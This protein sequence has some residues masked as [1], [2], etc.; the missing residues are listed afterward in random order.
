MVVEARFEGR[1]RP[2]TELVIS[3]LPDPVIRESRGRLICALKENGLRVPSG[4]LYLN[5]VPAA[6]RK[7]GGMLDLPIALGAAAAC[8]HIDPRWLQDTLFVGELGIDG[9]LHPVPGGLAAASCARESGI[10]QLV[11]SLATAREAAWIGEVA[12]LGARSLGQVVAHLSGAGPLLQALELSPEESR[13]SNEAHPS[14]DDVRGQ[15]HA[16]RALAVAALGAHGLLMVGPPG[17][18]K[19]MLARR[20]AGLL[21]PPGRR[22]CIEITL[23][24]SASGQ[25]PGGLAQARPFRAPHHTTSYA[26]LVGGGSPP[27]PGE[28]SLAHHGLLFLDELPEFPRESLE[29]LREPL[30]AGSVCISRAG[31]R[32]TFPAEFQLAAAMNPCPCGYR[33][34]SRV[35]CRCSP[36]MVAR[37]RRRISGPLLDRIDLRVDLVPPEVVE[38]LGAPSNESARASEDQPPL[39][40]AVQA[41]IEVVRE[42]Q[43]STPNSRLSTEQLDRWVPLDSRSKRLL[44][45]AARSRVYSARALQSLRRVARS[46]AD[47]DGEG[48]VT[49]EHLAQAI[50]LRGSAIGE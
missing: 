49:C 50:A 19:T 17:A 11:A 20:L 23:A 31:S 44:E 14:L 41:A 36:P 42:R 43:G 10:K 29:A 33:G 30:E 18:G 35:P 9:R 3:G 2:G 12:C 16:K 22:E 32:V 13:P 46:V 40:E 4:V 26:G 45:S 1:D 15:A 47:L 28:V 8:G 34:H 24:L 38:L 25:W 5:L 39:Q 27:R 37:Y 7:V 21:P 6:R 48:R